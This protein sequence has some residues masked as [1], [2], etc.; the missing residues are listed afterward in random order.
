MA[1]LLGLGVTGTASV[2]E[3]QV[4]AFGAPLSDPLSAES[5]S[6]ALAFSSDTSVEGGY[7]GAEASAALRLSERLSLRIRDPGLVLAVI[8]SGGLDRLGADGGLGGTS[9]ARFELTG[10]PRESRGPFGLEMGLGATYSARALGLGDASSYVSAGGFARFD[11]RVSGGAPGAEETRLE[12]RVGPQ[13]EQRL[14]DTRR[15]WSGEL[16]IGVTWR[17]PWRHHVVSVGGAIFLDGT[18]MPLLPR[19]ILSGVV[20]YQFTPFGD[21]GRSYL[22]GELRAGGP[23]GHKEL[24][25]EG[26]LSIGIATTVLERTYEEIASE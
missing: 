6:S 18:D 10:V 16:G 21:A 4:T 9:S 20:R 24:G 19:S 22:Y 5:G 1:A 2:A 14:E 25:F 7:S 13:F 15:G 11:G 26:T 17:S 23:L 12:L 3:A 8:G